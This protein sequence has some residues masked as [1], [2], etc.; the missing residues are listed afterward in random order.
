[1][2]ICRNSELIQSLDVLKSKGSFP[3]IMLISKQTQMRFL[4]TLQVEDIPDDWKNGQSKLT[5]D[6]VQKNQDHYIDY[7]LHGNFERGLLDLES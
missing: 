5:V 1:M 6:F 3:E 7:F 4:Q 2:N